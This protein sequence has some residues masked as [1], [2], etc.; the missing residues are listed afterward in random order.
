MLLLNSS[1]AIVGSYGYQTEALANTYKLS[2]RL[3]ISLGIYHF[4]E[5]NDGKR[6]ILALLTK[7][8]D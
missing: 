4:D 5:L 6:G 8:E 3:C 1:S 2:N 7:A